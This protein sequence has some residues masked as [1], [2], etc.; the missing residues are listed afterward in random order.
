MCGVGTLETSQNKHEDAIYGA[1]LKQSN[2]L[3]PHGVDSM[4][5]RGVIE[6]MNEHDLSV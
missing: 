1:C 5:G 3:R 4:G 2:C 6:S